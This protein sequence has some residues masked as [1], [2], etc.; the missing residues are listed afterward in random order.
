MASLGQ[1]KTLGGVGSILVLLSPIPY[2]GAVL[3][4]V[5]FIMIL[6]A[7][8]YIAD[9]LGDQKIFNNMIISVVLAII[10]IVVGVVVVLSAVY[11]LI[12]LG[13]YTY[14]PGTTTL[15]TGFSAVIVS[16]IAGLIV[17][18]IFYLVASIFLKRSY[19]T[20]ATR[21]NIGMFHTTGLLYLIGAATAIIF[22]GFIIVF[23]AEILQIVSFFSLPEQM[24]M[25]LQPMPGQVGPPPATM[26]ID[27]TK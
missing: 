1:A 13:R 2:A 22:V 18:W 23:I 20:I 14:N 6:I 12:G 4:I 8:K 15:P 5:G 11:S 3:A 26:S 7:V 25:G 24:P 10:G 9:V 16:I 17:I 21:L 19:D 27:R